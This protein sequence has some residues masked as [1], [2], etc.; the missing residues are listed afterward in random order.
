MNKIKKWIEKVL[1][2]AVIKTTE[3]ECQ[4]RLYAESIEEMRRYE[5]P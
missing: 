1:D 2:K 4:T 3:W 5:H